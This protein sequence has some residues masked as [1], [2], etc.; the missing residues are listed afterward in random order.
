MLGLTKNE[1]RGIKE[2]KDI[3][4]EITAKTRTLKF[5]ES[6]IEGEYSE[7]LNYERHLENNNNE[8]EWIFAISQRPTRCA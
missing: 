5:A 6:M 4:G 2:W 1:G 8:K 3:L 7:L